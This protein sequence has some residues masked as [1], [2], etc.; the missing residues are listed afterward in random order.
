MPRSQQVKCH[1][2]LAPLGTA[3]G[4]GGEPTSSRQHFYRLQHLSITPLSGITGN[5]KPDSFISLFYWSPEYLSRLTGRNHVV[6]QAQCWLFACLPP[7][8]SSIFTHQQFIAAQPADSCWELSLQSPH[9]PPPPLAHLH[10]QPRPA[11]TWPGLAQPTTRAATAL[12]L[13]TPG[14]TGG[15]RLRGLSC[16][17]NKANFLLLLHNF[18]RIVSESHH[19][20]LK[21]TLLW[22]ID[23]SLGWVQ[24]TKRSWQNFLLKP[25]RIGRHWMFQSCTLGLCMRLRNLGGS[26]RTFRLEYSVY[27]LR[28]LRDFLGKFPRLM[29]DMTG[30]NENNY[31]N[32]TRQTHSQFLDLFTGS[33]KS[34]GWSSKFCILNLHAWSHLLSFLVEDFSQE[35]FIFNEIRI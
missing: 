6:C 18:F 30:R 11:T 17:Q 8:L 23:D 21:N 28:N 26:L 27:L 24:N 10:N 34:A 7:L 1:N 33:L 4:E 29:G 9:P 19:P 31:Y 3:A 32:R 16:H 5:I 25:L 13:R 20:T 15:W 35:Y 2:T 14:N 12:T 22:G